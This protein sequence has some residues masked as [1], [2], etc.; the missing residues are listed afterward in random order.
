PGAKLSG[1][2]VASALPLSRLEPTKKWADVVAGNVNAVARVSGT[3][4]EMEAEIRASV[5]PLMLGRSRLPGSKLDIHLKP[6]PSTGRFESTLSTC[7]HKIPLP[8]DPTELDKDRA[9]G[10]FHVA[11]QLFGQQVMFDKFSI[12]R[13][14]H[15]VAK[16]GLIF[17][18]LN[19]GP[20]VEL[21]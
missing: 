20:L 2:V 10:V 12:T 17:N 16:G 11:G 21:R 19:L 5:S 9:T 4:D 7:G 13:Q 3:L 14:K 1:S 8:L 15:S 6:A 18:E